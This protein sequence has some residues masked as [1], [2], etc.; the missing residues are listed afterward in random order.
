M[1][2]TRVL[3]RL[4]ALPLL[5]ASTVVPAVMPLVPAAAHAAAGHRH[6]HHGPASDRCCDLC[7]VSCV[8]ALNT[9]SAAV[10]AR[11]QAVAFADPAPLPD[12]SPR[13]AAHD[14]RLPPLLGP[15]ALHA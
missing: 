11:H 14:V 4:L 10:A 13:R 6:Q 1:P 15:P 5:A 8:T 3:R 7:V 12:S 9:A 2:L